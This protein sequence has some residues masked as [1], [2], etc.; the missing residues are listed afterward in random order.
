MR[1]KLSAPLR[2]CVKI[3]L[4]VGGFGFFWLVIM[5]I[6]AKKTR[7]RRCPYSLAWTVDNPVRRRYMGQVLDHIGIRS[8][9]RVLELGC[10]PG[11]FTVDAARRAGS[12]GHLISIDVQPRMVARMKERVQEAGLTHVQACVADASRLPLADGSVER[13]FLITVLPEIPDPVRA[14]TELR[15][16]V[17]SDGTLSVTEEFLSPSYPL[18]RTVIRWAEEAGFDLQERHGSWWIYALNFGLSKPIR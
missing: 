11:V 16:V 10:G 4:L 2:L 18:A 12:G 3:L 7:H 17:R 13:A 14:L 9:E 1:Q 15:R 6:L 5:R 8:G